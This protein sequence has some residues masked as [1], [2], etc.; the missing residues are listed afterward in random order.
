MEGEG[1]GDN[2]ADGYLIPEGPGASVNEY[3]HRSSDSGLEGREASEQSEKNQSASDSSLSHSP[4]LN[5]LSC[6]R[7]VLAFVEGT[8]SQGHNESNNKG[9]EWQCIE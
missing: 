9:D 8:A 3:W 4:N 1:R 5:W 2:G 6:R 7:P